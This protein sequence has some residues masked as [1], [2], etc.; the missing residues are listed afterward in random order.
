MRP[1]PDPAS[2]VASMKSEL[3]AAGG[4]L[5][6]NPDFLRGVLAGCGDCM[7]I[8]DLDGRLQF[9]SEGGKR[10]MEVEDFGKLK[11]SSWRDVWA[12]RGN[13]EA[14]AAVEMARAGSVARFKGIANTA[15]GNPKYWDV[16]VSP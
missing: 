4:G 15:N 16:Q 2:T 9:M 10:V 8:L 3:I 11:G 12:G 13:T 5:V 6:D 1:T 14:K 7:K